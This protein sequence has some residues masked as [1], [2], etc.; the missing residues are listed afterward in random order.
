MAGLMTAAIRGD[1][2][3]Y[4]EFLRLRGVVGRAEEAERALARRIALSGGDRRELRE[5]EAE[6]EAAG[7]LRS[8][9]VLVPVANPVGL[10]QV[11]LDA[12]L[13]RFE[14]Q[15]GE[16]FNRNFVDLSDSIGDLIEEHLT[17]DPTHNLA[18]IRE[19][20]RRGLD[21]HP[22]RTPLQAQRLIL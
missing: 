6:L 10:E 15:S 5:L 14:L 20:L 3:A 16:N 1:E 11:L 18:L 8:E 9:I 12:P 4:A 22:V 2:A 7:R 13:G 19:Y 21:A 17:Q